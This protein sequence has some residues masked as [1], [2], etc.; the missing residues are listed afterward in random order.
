MK[1]ASD[2]QVMLRQFRKILR[3]RM[4]NNLTRPIVWG[5]NT[6]I[7]P[8]SIWDNVKRVSPAMAKISRLTSLKNRINVRLEKKI[9]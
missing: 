7:S 1:P 4:E 5:I 8:H 2:Y 6:A 3:K 9:I